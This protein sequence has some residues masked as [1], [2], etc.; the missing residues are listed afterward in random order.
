MCY[1]SPLPYLCYTP[2]VFV[3]HQH[4]YLC[5]TFLGICCT[6]TP[7]PVLY[8]PW[9]MLL[10][11]SPTFFIHLLVFAL[12]Q[13]PYLCYTFLGICCTPTPP[14]FAIHPLVFALDQPGSK[15]RLKRRVL[16]HCRIGRVHC[17][18]KFDELYI[19]QLNVSIRS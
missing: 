15:T 4:P 11:N 5:Y 6:L 12:H 9:Y 1:T 7:L 18:I 8:F 13:H 16:L 19:L 2:L 17:N 14:T 3:V 10:T